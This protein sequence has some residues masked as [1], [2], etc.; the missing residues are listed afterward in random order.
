VT[1]ST[2]GQPHTLQLDRSPVVCK[3]C[4]PRAF[5]LTR[6]WPP[7]ALVIAAGWLNGCGVQ[8]PPRPPR[9]QRPA[10]I[11]GLS[12]VQVGQALEIH[13]SVP[14]QTSDG[15]RLTKPL[16]VEILRSVA[17]PGAGVSKL[18]E[19]EVWM[20]L[21]RN[22]W[23]PYAKG[24]E[25]S[26][27]AHLTEQELR[28]WRGQTL[29]LGV[30]TLT[31]GLR[32]RALESDPS[33]WVD[34]PIFDVSEPVGGVVIV[35]TEKALE[36][37]FPPPPTML[38]GQPLHDLAGYRIYRSTTGERGSFE[39][40][41]ETPAP[42]YRDSQFEFGRTY[43]YR[44]RA[45]FGEPGHWAM[46]DDSQIATVTARDTFPPAA[47][48]GLTGIYAAGGVEL[49][50]TA[51]AESDLAGYYV[52]RLEN[53]PPQRLNKQLVRTPIFR[54]ANAV[55]GRTFSYYVTAVDLTGNESQPSEKV[56]VETK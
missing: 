54:D 16:E 5:R 21:I 45:V 3:F 34:V 24:G 37:R 55:P 43:Y 46:S 19:P 29:V 47:P 35:T 52:Y 7:L 44:V 8:G 13:F 26:Y 12:V 56:D 32:H 4:F 14:Q 15:Q 40:I 39:M 6:V 49:V 50:W 2:R 22:Q 25:V 23:L 51:N 1:H 42:P 41:G 28:T 38:S 10:T 27:T 11:T 20:R 18:P 30:R 31:R 9:L 33:N 53:P 36:V 48:Q 17:P